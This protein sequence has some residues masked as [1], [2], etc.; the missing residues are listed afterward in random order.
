MSLCI[1]ML[2][3][4]WLDQQ[5]LGCRST[6]AVFLLILNSLPSIFKIWTYSKP[7]VI[8]FFFSH[9]FSHYIN[10][11][12]QCH[13]QYIIESYQYW[14]CTNNINYSFLCLTVYCGAILLCWWSVFIQATTECYIPLE[15]VWRGDFKKV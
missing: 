8:V 7:D 15:S 9:L 6:I 14:Y 12:L 4:A 13:L 1:S 10:K 11:S 5:V 2:I 3:S